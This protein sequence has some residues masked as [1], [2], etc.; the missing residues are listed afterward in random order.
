MNSES[1]NI[2]SAKMYEKLKEV[3]LDGGY[4]PVPQS[5]ERHAVKALGGRDVATMSKRFRYLERQFRQNEGN[6]KADL[7]RVKAKLKLIEE[8]ILK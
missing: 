6:L 1:E 3:G 5:L 4:E 2:V 8:G 7:G